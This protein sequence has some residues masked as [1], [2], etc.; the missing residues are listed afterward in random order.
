MR[1]LMKQFETLND[2]PRVLGLTATLLNRNC[3][4][5]KVI[6]EVKALETTYHSKVA[7]VEELEAVVGYSTNPKE[8]ITTFHKYNLTAKE[9]YVVALLKKIKLG[10]KEVQ[11]EPVKAPIIIKGLK[12]LSNNEGTKNLRNLI[13]DLIYHIETMGSYG[14]YRACLAHVIQIE[15]IKKHCE[16]F[17]LFVLFTCVQTTFTY[18]S[19]KL[20]EEINRFDKKEAFFKTSSDQVVQLLRIIKNY[21]HENGEDLCCLIFT[22]RRFTAKVIYHLINDISRSHS[23][24][25]HIKAEFMVGNN[26]NPYKDTR[27]ALYIHK[28]SKKIIERFSQ[29]EINILVA[30]NVLEEGVDVPKC[31][32]VIKYD[33]PVDYR[34]YIQSK[35]R[36][37]HKQSFY[38]IMVSN[39][40]LKKFSQQYMEYQQIE[41]IL[42]DYL[43]GKN[44]EREEP[45]QQDIEAMYR[46]NEIAPYYVAGPG[47]AQVNMTSAISLLCQYCQSLPSDVYTSLTPDWY[48]KHYGSK[49]SVVILLPTV[50]KLLDLIEGPPMVTLRLAK[51]A[52]ALKACIILHKAGELDDHLLPIKNVLKEEDINFL[53]S[54][55]PVKDDKTV[56]TQKK[57]RLH[58]KLIPEVI[59]A[60][61]LP[62]STVY[63]H[64]IQLEP[65]FKQQTEDISHS[66]LFNMYFSSLCYGLVTQN[67]LPT[68]CAF[69][70][71]VNLGT[72]TVSL[73]VNESTVTLTDIDLQDIKKFHMNIFGNVINILKSF[74][75]FDTGNE[76]EMMLLVPVNK[77]DKKIDWNVLKP[78]IEINPINEMSNDEKLKMEVT[79]E[80]HLRRIVSP[81]YRRDH[82]TYI[83][84]EVCLSRTANSPFPNEDYHTFKEYFKSKHNITIRNP[85]LPLLLVKGLTKSL[86][87]IK[88]R[89]NKATKRKYDKLYVELEE[90]LPPE[91]V[92][93]Q[94][95]PA[96]LWIQASFL[97]T[98][99]TRISFM[100]QLE[101]FRCR[102]AREKKGLG[103]EVVIVK[104]PLELDDYVLDYEPYL[105][106]EEAD[107]EIT[108]P[109]NSI[110]QALPHPSMT[111]NQDFKDKLLETQYPWKN[112]EEPKDVERNLDVTIMD[113]EHYEKFICY[114]VSDASRELRNT[115]DPNKT[116]HLALTY[117]KNFVPVKINMLDTPFGTDGPELCELYRA[118]TAAKANEIVNL[119]R[120]ETLGD[121]FLKL[122]TSVYI[123]LRFPEYDEGRATSL[124]GRM[125][126]NRNLFY[127]ALKKNI[128]GVIKYNELN[129]DDF[130]PP[131][132]AIPNEMLQRIENKEVSIDA[133]FRLSIPFEEQV[134]GELSKKTIEGI[135][136]QE[137]PL[138][139]SE[140]YQIIAPFSKYQ[141]YSDKHT[142]DAVEGL[143]GIYYQ[144]LGFEG[145]IKFLEWLGLIPESEHLER[146]LSQPSPDPILT[147]DDFESKI[148]RHLP[149]QGEIEKIIGYKF[150]NKAFLLQA[151]THSSYTPNRTTLSYE[152]LEFIG[153]AVLD[154]LITCHIY[155]SCGNLDPGKLT[156][157]RSALVNN[158]TFASLV[159][160]LGLHKYILMVNSKLQK[161]IDKFVKF[162]EQKNYVIDD[163][164]MILVQEDEILLAES[165]DVPKVLGDIFEAIAGAVYL[166]SNKDLKKVWEVFYKIM[167]KEIDLFS[168]NV[169]M[170]VVR[171]IFEWPGAQPKFGKPCH[172]VNN[173]TM[174]ALQFML[175]RIPTSVHG[176]GTNKVTAKKAAAKLA[177]HILD[178]RNK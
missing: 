174:I 97:P 121:S 178:V 130:L 72:I 151:L 17:N 13:D 59:K 55:Y 68:I 140:D 150:K 144:T 125:V 107:I 70:I 116:K 54:H 80:S 96:C 83:V 149:L 94:D 133:I 113:I 21:K 157:L 2:P 78:H 69:P 56:G 119:E 50:C 4:L 43:I 42:N 143:T 26:S 47:S 81:W 85:D 89:G 168:T 167:W 139:D 61:I 6:E 20:Q 175:D 44:I 65:L 159:V 7:T 45:S 64:I 49:K 75:A 35:G 52:A 103:K 132:L 109:S 105:E 161:L 135:L 14:G 114:G 12:P 76:P 134:S 158:I 38:N 79:Q 23:E 31:T 93:K 160:K 163:E 66:T 117:H 122:L 147:R 34:S 165:V 86:N 48:V 124:K 5:N 82:S 118:L 22:Q 51:R 25:K 108:I 19:K 16:D 36:A 176:F 41:T 63:L 8:F 74:V 102:I 169:P 120:L 162:M 148:R 57:K 9:K 84:T 137:C 138:T 98:I 37:R 123:Y 27:E 153:D 110:V 91:L 32:L 141:Y 39:D 62:F 10:I 3:K 58:K 166:D 15:R 156:D 24:Y 136:N 177:L 11:F 173:R 142:A 29:K 131:A 95:F 155:E 171:K 18:V 129:K 40:N 87:F 126:S 172:T 111:I 92:V 53:F 30:S 101:E 164:V 100:L 104:K 170:N 128:D 127:L 90:Y 115:V 67:P 28:Q 77:Q 145:G 33:L 1:Q 154:F 99:L 71:Y 106:E 60:P 112:I 46:E 73:K 146:L 88:P 152:K